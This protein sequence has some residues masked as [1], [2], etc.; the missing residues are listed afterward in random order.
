MLVLSR[1]VG[2]SVMIGDD[3]VV[4][5]LDVRG[6]VVRLGVA[7]PRSVAVHREELLAEIARTNQDSA[8]PRSHT[9]SAL[10]RAVAHNRRKDDPEPEQPDS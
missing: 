1:R 7:A 5:V 10:K 2:E 9:V 6:E 8:S 4:T 3:V